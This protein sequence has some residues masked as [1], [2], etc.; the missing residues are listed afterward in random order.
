MQQSRGVFLK[1]T[2]HQV[3]GIFW[4]LYR[5]IGR[6]CQDMSAY[7]AVQLVNAKDPATGFPPLVD[8]LQGSVEDILSA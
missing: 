8:L 4:N 6:K 2:N 5:Y 1:G 3:F 7:T